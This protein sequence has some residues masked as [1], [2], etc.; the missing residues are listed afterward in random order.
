MKF[1]KH[2]LTSLIKENSFFFGSYLL[3]LIAGAVVLLIIDKGDAVIFFNDWRGSSCDEVFKFFSGVGEGLYFS[4]FLLIIGIFSFRY[5]VLGVTIYLAS[6][7]ITQILK[8]IFKIPRPKVFFADTDLVTYVDNFRLLANN[9]FP[10]GHTTSGFAIFLFLALITRNKQLGMAYLFCA[11]LVGISRV[12]LVQ[13]FFI[14]V[15][16]GSLIG[17]FFTLLIYKL[18]E[19]S[20]K[21]VQSNWYNFSL[22]DYLK[23]KY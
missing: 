2:S 12:Y 15:Y 5:I 22:Y 20:Q 6:V 14:D 18:F 19:N 9:A 4:I 23:G 16:F 1:N 11:F 3:F 8:N 13:H 7:G 17:V 21:I 10:S